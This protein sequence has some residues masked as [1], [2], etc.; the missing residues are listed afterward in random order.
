MRSG[1]LILSTPGNVTVGAEYRRVRMDF[2]DF[3]SSKRNVNP[4]ALR[5]LAHIAQDIR[6]LE[7]N[8]SLFSKSLVS[9]AAVAEYPYADQT[10]DGRDVVTVLIQIGQPR[11]SPESVDTVCYSGATCSSHL[12]GLISETA[13]LDACN[14]MFATINIAIGNASSDFLRDCASTNSREHEKLLSRDGRSDKWH[15]CAALSCR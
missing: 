7:R 12:S 2:Q 15:C 9:R 8:A 14:G 4:S 5:I 13:H 11:K 1:V 10:H 3:R 6:Q